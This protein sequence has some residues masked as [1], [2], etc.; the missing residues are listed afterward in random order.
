[1]SNIE[2]LKSLVLEGGYDDDSRRRVAQLEERL[3]NALM[4]ERLLDH[5]VIGEYMAHVEGELERIETLLLQDRKLT[6]SQRS[7]LFMYRDVLERFA[8]LFTGKE[9]EQVEQSINQ[10]LETAKNA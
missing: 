5:P 2:Q 3:Q 10:L 4:A 8:G 1:M 7:A 6:E 9:T